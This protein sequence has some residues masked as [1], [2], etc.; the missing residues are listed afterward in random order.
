MKETVALTTIALFITIVSI[1][2]AYYSYIYHS[3]MAFGGG[4]LGVG[5]GI[6]AAF[7]IAITHNDPY[8]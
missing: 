4:I 2:I 6:F 1:V 8:V 3:W 5:I 7:A